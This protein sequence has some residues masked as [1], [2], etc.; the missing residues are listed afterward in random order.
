[1]TLGQQK[2]RHASTTEAAEKEHVLITGGLGFI[3]THVADGYL[4]AGHRVS[5]LD[6][7]V[8]AVTDGAWYRGNPN[9]TIIRE[10]VEA[11]FAAGGTLAPFDRV[12]HA[13][14]HVG[15]AGILKYAGRLGFAIVD[16]THQMIEACLK[17]DKP[18]CTFSSAETY[19]RSGDLAEGDTIEVPMPYSAR[20]EY[21]IA[22]TLTEC[23]LA[24]SIQRGLRAIAIRPFNVTGPRQSKAGGF[25]MPTFVQQGLMGQ[26]MTIFHTGEQTRAFLSAVDLTLFL[27]EFMD[28][29]LASGQ[30]VFNVGNPSN[31]IT[32]RALADHINARLG[33]P[34]TV[35]YADA[36]KIHGALYE[37][38]VSIHKTPVI[39]RA[40]ALGWEPRVDLE[41]LIDETIDFYRQHEDM[42]ARELARSAA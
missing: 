4:A 32:V 25:V 27:V 3:G 29:A 13:A 20:I 22:K 28:K 6:S 10:S 14:S 35:V 37:E 15:P 8:A 40:R 33:N 1:M 30:Q 5:L 11:Y 12:I 21:A 9:V 38:A 26:P 2:A 42:R 19:G 16:A 23:M 41:A 17:E 34:S 36:K 31:R 39:D 18:L 24:N 7:M